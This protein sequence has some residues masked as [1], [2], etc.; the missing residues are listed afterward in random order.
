MRRNLSL[1]LLPGSPD[2][3]ALSEAFNQDV[4]VF[5]VVHFVNDLLP[6]PVFQGAHL[7]LLDHRR[8]FA[9]C[10]EVVFLSEEYL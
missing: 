7:D 8:D 4:D 1:V 10:L 6:L 5:L 2:I 3:D 9:L